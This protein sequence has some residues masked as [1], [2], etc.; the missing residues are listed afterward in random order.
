MK[1]VL[2]FLADGFEEVEALTPVDYLRRS[3]VEVD[4]VSIK[5]DKHVTS[6][7]NVTVVADL[8]IDKVNPNDYAL[9]FVP[10]GMPGATNLR[11]DEK[12]IE[13]IKEI[14]KNGDFVSAVCAGPIVLERAGVLKDKN[15]TSFPTMKDE[16]KSVKNYVEDE[17]VV[18]DS[19]V[20]TSRGAATSAYLAFEMV[21][22]LKGKDA[23]RKLI[24][25]IQ[26]DKV[27]KFYGFES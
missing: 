2:V 27:E 19:N 17:V 3:G 15:A 14:N 24:D 1:K 11:D 6:S 25:A 16:L 22:L 4:T 23:K 8:T 13:I 21:E 20:L 7:H 26:Q 5:N 10:G 12:V 9:V 18:K